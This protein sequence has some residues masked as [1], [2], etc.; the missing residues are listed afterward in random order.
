MCGLALLLPFS[1]LVYLLPLHVVMVE[2]KGRELSQVLYKCLALSLGQPQVALS[3][4]L[5][6]ETKEG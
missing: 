3:H 4:F 1:F 6:E 2:G 5:D